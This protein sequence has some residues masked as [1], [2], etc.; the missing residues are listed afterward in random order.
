MQKYTVKNT[1][2]DIHYFLYLKGRKDTIFFCIFAELFSKSMFLG[3][4]MFGVTMNVCFT[5]G[6]LVKK[7]EKKN[8][9]DCNSRLL[10][11]DD[12]VSHLL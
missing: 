8:L 3:L 6:V 11:I 10:C 9:D 4:R 12:G 2:I 1:I 7:N 5:I